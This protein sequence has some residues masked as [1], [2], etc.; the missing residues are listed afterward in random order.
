MAPLSHVN[1][2]EEDHLY[3]MPVLRPGG[4]DLYT[5]ADSTVQILAM[6][7]IHTKP[8]LAQSRIQSSKKWSCDD[9]ALDYNRVLPSLGP[10][11]SP[12]PA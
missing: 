11:W 8:K 9:W 1:M 6:V 3:E 12:K 10:P 2:A 7:Q 5:L 4:L